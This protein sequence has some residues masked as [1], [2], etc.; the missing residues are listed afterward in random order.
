MRL[1]ERGFSLDEADAMLESYRREGYVLVRGLVPESPIDAVARDV[2]ALFALQLRRLDLPI[3]PYRDA[4]TLLANMQRVFDADVQIYLATARHAAKLATLQQLAVAAPVMALAGRLGLT[5]PT[6]PTTPVL[7]IMADTL[8]IPDG[9]FGVAPHQDWP[10]IQGGLDTFTLW[11]SLFDVDAEEF[12]VEVIPGSHRN[13]LWSGSTTD[14]ALEIDG[15]QFR[16]ADFVRV[17]VRRGDVLIFTGFT[18]H[19]TAL[20]GC[21]GLRIASS[22]RYEN[23]AEPTFAARGYPCAYQRTVKRDFI[24]PDFPAATQVLAALGIRQ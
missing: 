13:G 2:D 9:Y 4:A 12:P 15:S 7:H 24:T 1:C 21:R 14:Y 18:V 20:E 10:S 8:R 11:L 6:L 3:S 19:R 16:D 5:A 22:T 23:A 17:P